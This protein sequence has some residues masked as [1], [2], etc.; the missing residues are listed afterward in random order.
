MSSI[1]HNKIKALG[2]LYER[3]GKDWTLSVS[4]YLTEPTAPCAIVQA[5]NSNALR[6]AAWGD[7]IEEAI[8]AS[9]EMVYRELIL[10]E[11]INPVTP[12]TN[13]DDHR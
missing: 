2:D 5:D 3:T 1:D 4:V 9:V 12:I 8:N 6:Y 7:T 11:T 13:S 10:G